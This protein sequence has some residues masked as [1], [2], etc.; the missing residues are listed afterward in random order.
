M[1][2]L[3]APPKIVAFESLFLDPN[4]PRLAGNEQPGY[5]DTKALLDPKRQAEL[6][7]KIA[8]V[9]PVTELE[10][11]ITNQGW[12]PIDSIV[13]WEPP[14]AHGKCVVVEG[15]TRIVALRRLRRELPRLQ[16]R[17]KKMSANKTRYATHDT[18]RL[19]AEVA[20]LTDVVKQTEQVSVAVL[21]ARNVEQLL[22]KLPRILAVRHITGVKEWGNYAQDVWLLNRY[23][24]VFRLLR[25]PD[26]RLTW[27]EPL[28]DQIA[29]EAA[30]TP[31]KVRRQILAASCH[32]H[33]TAEY[34]DSLPKGEEFK[35]GDYYL[36]E[37]LVKKPWLRE[38]LGLLNGMLHLPTEGEEVLFKWA[39]AKPRGRNAEQNKN[40]FYRHENLLVL[41]Q[42]HR[43]DQEH[44]TGFAARFDFND[45]DSAPRVAEVEAAWHVHKESSQPAAVIEQLLQQLQRLDSKMLILEGTFLRKQLQHLRDYSDTVLAM[46]DAGT[47][48]T[49][50]HKG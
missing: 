14:N 43:Y 3:L 49:A 28:I 5:T 35:T 16:E 20:T 40:I 42:M 25:G 6:E 13:V 38:Q 46:I 18:E 33:F 11:A 8:A 23:E 29:H 12:Q 9:Y 1:E 37:N 45:P 22:R 4:N 36:F 2:A 30:L 39:F 10:L 50:R 7:D 44:N 15:N 32:S 47:R 27:E 41:D 31:T 48:S 34:A 24:H 19:K 17:L 26:A 21:L